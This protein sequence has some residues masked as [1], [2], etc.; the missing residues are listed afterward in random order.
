MSAEIGLG[1]GDREGGIGGKVERGVTFAPVSIMNRSELLKKCLGRKERKGES[2]VLNHGNVDGS[3]RA[4]A[5]DFLVP[6]HIRR[7]VG[8]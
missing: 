5:V 8:N 1:E 6:H 3:S 2:F 7:W 4:C